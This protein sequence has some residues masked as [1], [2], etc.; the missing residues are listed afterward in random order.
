MTPD[1]GTV[2]RN[3]VA[4]RSLFSFVWRRPVRRAAE[5]AVPLLLVVPEHDSMA[6]IGPVLRLAATAPSAE[7]PRVA[8][9]HY[10]VYEGGASFADTVAAEVAFLGRVTAR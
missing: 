7:L 1:D 6:P 8:G 4:A 3:R 10:D 5:V 9:G 2:W